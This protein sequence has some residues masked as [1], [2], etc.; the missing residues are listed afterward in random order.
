MRKLV[1]GNELDPGGEDCF[2]LSP[3]LS[4]ENSGLAESQREIR[5]FALC[6]R[7]KWWTN[8][9]CWRLFQA[10]CGKDTWSGQLNQL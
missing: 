6:Q 8:S 4:D 3:L 7:T 2:G 9:T 1:K 10:K 5:G